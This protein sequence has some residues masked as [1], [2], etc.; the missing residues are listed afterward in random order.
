MPT[1]RKRHSITETEPVAAALDALRERADA[2]VDLA[3]LVVLGAQEKLQRLESED[4]ARRHRN[5]LRQRFAERTVTG[6]GVDVDA[7]LDAH[8]PGWS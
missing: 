4:A 5:A 1:Q 8:R 6:R 3:E 2:R 7:L